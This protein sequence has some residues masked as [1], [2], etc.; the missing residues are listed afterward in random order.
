MGKCDHKDGINIDDI[1]TIDSDMTRTN[2]GFKVIGTCNHIGCMKVFEI[3][4]TIDVESIK[5]K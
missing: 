1:L 5:E 3:C 2:D 4:F